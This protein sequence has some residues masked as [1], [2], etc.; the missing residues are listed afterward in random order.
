[1]KHI[2]EYNKFIKLN[3]GID[4]YNLSIIKEALVELEDLGWRIFNINKYHD[5]IYI[6][7]FTK[8]SKISKNA[9]CN[10]KFDKNGHQSEIEPTQDVICYIE[11]TPNEYEQTVI[12]TFI[13][14]S[15]L[16]LNMIDYDHGELTIDNNI[17][18]S[19]SEAKIILHEYK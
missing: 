4:E 13:D 17:I 1:M 7:L 10:Y 9:Y 2:D 18:D 8:S 16:I 14:R 19:I 15:E 3:E 11:Y 6:R 5:H 12:D